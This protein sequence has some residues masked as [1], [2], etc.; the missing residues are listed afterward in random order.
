VNRVA[1]FGLVACAA[2]AA[3]CSRP[4]SGQISPPA[5]HEK[6]GTPVAFAPEDAIKKLETPEDRVIY[7]HQLKNDKSFEPDKHREMLEKYAGDTDTEVAAAAKELL[8]SKN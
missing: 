5:G 3:G 1:L 6:R 8:E 2:F 7:L 4:A